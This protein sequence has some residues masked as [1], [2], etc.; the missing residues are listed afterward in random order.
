MLAVS[1]PKGGSKTQSVPNL[2]SKLR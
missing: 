1:P 2:N